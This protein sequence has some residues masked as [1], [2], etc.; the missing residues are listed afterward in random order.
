MPSSTN[1]NAVIG[2][3]PLAPHPCGSAEMGSRLRRLGPASGVARL[4][5]AASSHL[6]QLA[7]KS[8]V[9]PCKVSFPDW[10]VPD[11]SLR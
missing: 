2:R 6:R 7:T 8:V 4:N 10:T 3:K 1:S 11:L 5:D 9:S